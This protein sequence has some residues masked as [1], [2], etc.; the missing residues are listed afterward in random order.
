M[1]GLE[2]DYEV[3]N[4]KNVT[5]KNIIDSIDKNDIKSL[6][7]LQTHTRAGT[8]CRFCMFEEGDFGVVKKKVYCKDILN[9]YKK[10]N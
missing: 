4:C 9:N 8:E 3:C 6:G 2:D 7:Q 1:F 5:I 10:E